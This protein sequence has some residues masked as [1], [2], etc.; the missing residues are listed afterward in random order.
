MLRPHWL[1]QT[2][3]NRDAQQSR[4]V[5]IQRPNHIALRSSSIV[6]PDGNRGVLLAYSNP[7]G[8]DFIIF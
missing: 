3:E 7:I 6:H 2:P 8:T 5:W 1:F 4:F